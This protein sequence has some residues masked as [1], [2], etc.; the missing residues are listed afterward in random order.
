MPDEAISDIN[1]SMHEGC[2]RDIMY[3]RIIVASLNR[4]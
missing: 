2:H 4:E 3:C 1:V